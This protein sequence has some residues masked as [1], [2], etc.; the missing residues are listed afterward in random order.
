MPLTEEQQWTEI[1]YPAFLG[2]IGNR[3]AS[4]RTAMQA[5][6]VEPGEADDWLE[7][8]VNQVPIWWREQGDDC[9]VRVGVRA[10]GEPFY[11]FTVPLQWLIG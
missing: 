6:P 5:I 1:N 10:N 3:I 8:N 9:I 11:L 4:A 2:A 7:T